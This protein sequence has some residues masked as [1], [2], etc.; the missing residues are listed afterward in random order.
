MRRLLLVLWLCWCGLACASLPRDYTN[1]SG[2]W[3][4]QSE[5]RYIYDGYQ[6]IQER[7]G[8]N[9]VLVTY[10]RGLD[11][12][13]SLAGAGGIGGLLARTDTNGSTFYHSDGAGNVTA[14]IDPQE[15]MAARYMY[16]AFGAL[17]SQHG[18]MAGVNRIMFSSKLRL[19]QPDMYDSGEREY[20][21]GLQR[22]GSPDPLGVR[23][24]TDA[25]RFN[26]NNPLSYIDP[27]GLAPQLVTLTA[28][29]NG[30]PTGA[31][32]ADYNLADGP[33][34]GGPGN[35]LVMLDPVNR[36][37]D[38][39]TQNL[40]QRIAGLFGYGNDASVVAEIKSQLD[41]VM[42]AG[43]PEM[44]EANELSQLGKLGK[45]KC[46]RFPK[47]G[48]QGTKP[49][50]DALKKIRQGGQKVDLGFIPTEEQ[51]RQLLEDAGVDLEKI[52]P[53]L[54][55]ASPNPHDYP[56]INYPTPSGG[57]GTIQIQ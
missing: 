3:I 25:Y 45:V 51:A 20:F 30:K 40:A 8:N 48:W 26:Y 12:S 38:R 19:S 5:T 18:G 50:K 35:P 57:K 9:N 11:L 13:A 42:M 53:E 14:L 47:L 7:D 2:A 41:F 15:N 44:G 43:L 52:R 33:Y 4:L 28:D 6:L 22:W 37:L 39:E 1:S 49:Y 29:A 27:D 46:E 23:F 31:G 16:S 54:P 55:H 24:D 17:V 21:T 56:H 36:E 34:R 10:T 32:Y